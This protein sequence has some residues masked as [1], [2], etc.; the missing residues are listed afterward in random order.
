MSINVARDFQLLGTVG[1]EAFTAALCVAAV[2]IGVACRRFII[3][4]SGSTLGRV[5]EKARYAVMQ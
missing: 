5:K 4:P 3:A 1:G 2:L